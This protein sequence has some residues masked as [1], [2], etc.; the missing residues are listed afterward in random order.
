[1]EIRQFY[2]KGFGAL[3]NF[4]PGPLSPGLNV[5][6]G[7]NEA[8][9][10]TILAFFNSMFF[11]FPDARRNEKQFD[12]VNGGVYGGQ[13]TLISER[14]GELTLERMKIRGSSV[15]IYGDDGKV[16]DSSVLQAIFGG[17]TR[18]LFK[19]VYS[20]SLEELQSLE[21]LKGK[22][23]KGAI[24]GAGY[25]TAFLSVPETEKQL[26]RECQQ[27]FKP[28]GRKQPLNRI[29]G[30]IAEVEAKLKRVRDEVD[31][32][33]ELTQALVFHRR[34]LVELREERQRV[35]E[36]LH[37][38]RAALESWDDWLLFSSLAQRISAIDEDRRV[39]MLSND[40][41]WQIEQASKELEIKSARQEENNKRLKE[42]EMRMEAS[43]PDSEFLKKRQEV[44]SLLHSRDKFVQ[45]QEYRQKLRH[46][47]SEAARLLDAA[48]KGLGAAWDARR[49]NETIFSVSD[50]GKV[51][52]FNKRFI[53]LRERLVRLDDRH[54]I[55]LRDRT[56]LAIQIKNLQ[57]EI[58]AIQGEIPAGI[59]LLP[60]ISS[61]I[62]Q[63][64]EGVRRLERLKVRVKALERQL[65]AGQAELCLAMD[66]ESLS[67]V[68][69][70]KMVRGSG[71]LRDEMEENRS[72]IARSSQ[73]LKELASRKLEIKKQINLRQEHLGN[74]TLPE[75]C[76]SLVE[77]T[78]SRA[79]A[80][81][82]SIS[83]SIA[84]A[85]ALE[86][87]LMKVREELT[88]NSNLMERL[89]QEKSR[90]EK[91]LLPKA[92]GLAG[93]LL[94][95]MAGVLFY[96]EKSIY[97]SGACLGSGVVS[98]LWSGFLVYQKSRR[99][100]QILLQVDKLSR[101]VQS[102]SLQKERLLSFLQVISQETDELSEILR[103]DRE[104]LPQS[105][106]SI[107]ED[108]EKARRILGKRDIIQA[109][110]DSFNR[111][112]ELVSESIRKEEGRY[113]QLTEEEKRLEARWQSFISTYRLPVGTTPEEMPL[114]GSKIS[115]LKDILSEINAVR[116]EISQLEKST[117]HHLAFIS[118]S[119]MG[120]AVSV[121]EHVDDGVLQRLSQDFHQIIQRREALAE[122][123][124]EL[125]QREK[126]LEAIDMELDEIGSER[127]K[128][129]KELQELQDQWKK[130]LCYK[131]LDDDMDPSTAMKTAD[132]LDKSQQLISVVDQKE[133]EIQETDEKISA[134]GVKVAAMFRQLL[135]ESGELPDV[136]SC[137]DI[138]YD[139]L[140]KEQ[141]SESRYRLLEKEKE[142]L[143]QERISL[144]K[145]ID[146]LKKEIRTILNRAGCENIPELEMLE[147]LFSER[148]E[149]VVLK[150]Q[151]SSKLLAMAGEEDMDA[152]SSFFSGWT[153][154]ELKE[155]VN[156]ISRQL[157]EI[158][159][160]IELILE[161]QAEANRALEGL[162]SSVEHQEL[163][164][165]RA[166][167]D[168]QAVALARRWAVL[169]LALHILERARERFESEN[170]P[171]VIRAAS[172]FF[173]TITRGRYS[174][175]EAEAGTD[176]IR[177]V[178]AQG[179]RVSPEK[180]SRGTAE[181]LY[182]SLRFGVIT[183]CKTGSERLP[184]L[185]D[186]I[187]VN[188]DPDRSRQAA[189]CIGE[190]SKKHQVIF[191]T[192]HPHVAKMLEEVSP[193]A[194]VMNLQV[195][196]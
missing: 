149:K 37:K 122:T 27:I 90:C 115:R 5:L 95:V 184:V 12:P 36:K 102:L 42:I 4:T 114:I 69:V 16:M 60:D 190:L 57:D 92:V 63:L 67:D 11:G 118:Q 66:E 181:Q 105:L 132:L 82:T 72:K 130:W 40:L 189:R 159:G 17:V 133:R 137:I 156:E 186:D 192:C 157:R 53:D 52:K 61:R 109:E 22:E 143:E 154:E 6:L 169:S 164:V 56:N 88:E 32:Y 48:I 83:G 24:Y 46:E 23:I 44:T 34:R 47:S 100:K 30:E 62:D 51:E 116:A 41:F 98:L 136:P 113:Q 185:M 50:R 14:H 91:T 38:F 111:E 33:R 45:L 21:T 117:R 180:L 139:R 191:L 93:F 20:F 79:H 2:I 84:H 55:R 77:G 86:T 195:V 177:A 148:Q 151:V 153:L 35:S 70:P 99:R 31:K 29:L 168:G 171:Q 101:K 97:Y 75:S 103:L 142:Q 179:L 7:P 152:V 140:V 120:L 188:F 80:L 172:S 65:S 25:G 73:T 194:R 59:D 147:G 10:S 125:L 158:D 196:S 106:S 127:L 178:S 165:R 187:L 74:F 112:L 175:I 19:N 135:G 182:L 89:G 173:N 26:T 119:G 126:E 163:L 128:L 123:E 176:E 15:R 58:A 170:Q 54:E 131:H 166:S 129:N 87:E 104:I 64:K 144:E 141:E 174:R 81:A 85:A 3:N 71:H 121:D 124:K 94:M 193:D 28:S 162:V 9:K 145:D 78:L 43:R 96:L 107:L 49:V 8:G 150:N 134:I 160:E 146:R 110:I 155:K 167:L 39:K 1:V 18:Q 108:L 13:I 161:K 68:D 76:S 183:S 138:L